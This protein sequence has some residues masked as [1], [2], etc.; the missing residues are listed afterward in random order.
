[1]EFSFSLIYNF[2]SGRKGKKKSTVP[3]S[4]GI[5]MYCLPCKQLS[6]TR[7]MR[8]TFFF[9][10][11]AKAWFSRSYAASNNGPH[12]YCTQL[13]TSCNFA[14][15]KCVFW[16][17]GIFFF[18]VKQH[19]VSSFQYEPSISADN[20]IF[21]ILFLL[22]ANLWRRLKIPSSDIDCRS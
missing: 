8:I 1:M 20:A 4:E 17:F 11:V 13:K 12:G 5:I 9:V 21:Y 19:L 6:E 10:L 18:M 14:Q 22:P 16:R 2:W 3:T 7:L 15:M